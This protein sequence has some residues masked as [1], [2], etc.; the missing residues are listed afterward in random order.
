MSKL[1][2]ILLGIS[3]IGVSAT[4]TMAQDSQAAANAEQDFYN[5]DK[6]VA[7]TDRV[8]EE[9][10]PV[11]M[12]WGAFRAQP[13]LSAGV[14]TDSNLFA[15]E[16]NEESDILTHI[17]AALDVRSNWNQ[18]ELGFNVSGRQ[19]EY[20]DFSSESSFDFRSRVF[21]RVDV[22][23]AVAVRG[24]AYFE[25]RTEERTQIANSVSNVD[26]IQFGVTGGTVSASYQND[27]TRLSAGLTLEERDFE[28]GRNADG[29]EFDQDFRDR[30]TTSGTVVASYAINPN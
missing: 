25:D 5:R 27:R 28:D 3:A 8:Q 7:V 23:R 24:E 16:T 18:N 30:T 21:G 22:S 29:T 9:Y 13:E 10:D 6:Y 2:F 4:P 15:S 20:S 17:A 14:T 1:K 12:N 19:N 26:P 11:R